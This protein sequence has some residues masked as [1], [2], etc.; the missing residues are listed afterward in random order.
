MDIIF[1]DDLRAE[2]I[3]GI[4]EKERNVKQTISIDLELGTSIA[5]AAQS[6]NIDDTFNYK[7]LS[8]RVEAYIKESEFQ[9]IETLAERIAE[10]ILREFDVTWL[11]LTLHKPGAL[12]NSKDVGIRIVRSAS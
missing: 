1:I 12:S 3:I 9:L 2:A 6:D 7:M 4:Y 11:K 10:L 8:K 5:K